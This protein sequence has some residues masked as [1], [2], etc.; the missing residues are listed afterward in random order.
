MSG[1]AL[2][3][4]GGNPVKTALSPGALVN[5]SKGMKTSKAS[6]LSVT[7]DLLGHKAECL[8]GKMSKEPI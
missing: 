4:R 1:K 7:Q 3:G 8:V 6:T 5:I 2:S